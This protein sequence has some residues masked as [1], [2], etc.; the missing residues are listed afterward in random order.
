RGG[1]GDRG[2]RGRAAPAVRSLSP[3]SNPEKTETRAEARVQQRSPLWAGAVGHGS[4][5]TGRFVLPA[6]PCPA[7]PQRCRPGQIRSVSD[8]YPSFPLSSFTF[9]YPKRAES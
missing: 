3:A 5:T 1:G 4:A 8:T 9:R 7:G 6:P 2:R